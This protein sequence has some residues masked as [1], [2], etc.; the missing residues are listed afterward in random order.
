MSEGKIRAFCYIVFRSPFRNG[1]FSGTGSQYLSDCRPTDFRRQSVGSRTGAIL[2]GAAY[3]LAPRFLWECLTSRTVSWFPAPASSNPACGFPALGLPECL[4]H[5][6]LWG[7][8]HWGRLSQGRRV[9][10]PIPVKQAEN[11]IEPLFTPSLPAET[12]PISGT[13]HVAPDL[14]FYPV[15]DK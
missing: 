3:P 7:L 8:S 10:N 4:P 13:H 11:T 14:L 6:G 9:G 1:S 5:Q 15:F 12:L 2:P